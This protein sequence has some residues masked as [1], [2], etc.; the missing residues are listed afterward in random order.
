MTRAIM[1]DVDGVM[2]HSHFHPDPARRRHWDE[3]MLIDMGVEPAVFKTLFTGGFD[4]AITGRTSLV[5]TL[6]A[7]LPTIGYTGSTLDFIGYWLERDAEINLQLLDG[8]R[9]LRASG[10]VRLYLA[11]NQEHLRANHLWNVLGLRHVFDDIFYSARLGVAK[12]A[13]DYF[14]RIDARLGRQA[15]APLIFDDSPKVIEAARQHGWEAALFQTMDDFTGH[16][17]I[18]ERIGR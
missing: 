11:T 1:I 6:D 8:L 2:V 3:H 15:I 16:S 9:R 7:F 4:A 12:P 13:P 14:A 5:E 18:A 17:W 10:D